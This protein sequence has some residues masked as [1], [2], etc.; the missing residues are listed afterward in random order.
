MLSKLEKEKLGNLVK[1][2]FKSWKLSWA[3]PVQTK[4]FYLKKLVRGA[5]IANKPSIEGSKAIETS[6]VTLR[7]RMLVN[8]LL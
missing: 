7:R 8:N 1:F 3:S 6:H 5:R 2:L 4:D